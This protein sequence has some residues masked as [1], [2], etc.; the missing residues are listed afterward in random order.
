MTYQHSTNAQTAAHYTS[1]S[2]WSVGVML[3]VLLRG[4]G[5]GLVCEFRV[6]FVV[7]A[8]SVQSTADAAVLMRP[9]QAKTDPSNH[10]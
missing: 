5:L 2:S 1:S 8:H 4:L 3:L 7:V 9:K 10:L 6:C